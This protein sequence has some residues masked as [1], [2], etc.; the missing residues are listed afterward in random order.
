M[1]CVIVHT[2]RDQT[3]LAGGGT[4]IYRHV[5]SVNPFSV[6][7]TFW[8]QTTHNL[9]GVSRKR[10]CSSKRDKFTTQTVGRLNVAGGYLRTIL[11]ITSHRDVAIAQ[12]S[13][14]HDNQD[15]ANFVGQCQSLIRV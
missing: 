12:R 7:V 4:K 10:D 14:S 5:S 3:F 15:N 1:V 9:R 13:T 2:H 8:G 6:T 11:E